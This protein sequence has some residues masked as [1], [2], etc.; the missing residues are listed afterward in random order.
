MKIIKL[1]GLLA[2]AY[3]ISGCAPEV[4]SDAWCEAL[5]KKSK[6]DWSTNEALDFA[7]NCL[8]D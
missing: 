3:M 8:V 5:G 1:F 6:A 2:V 4:G 7:K